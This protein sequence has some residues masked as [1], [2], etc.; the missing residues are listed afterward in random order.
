MLLWYMDFAGYFSIAAV[1]K[2]LIIPWYYL[3]AEL[4]HRETVFL[5]LKN[6]FLNYKLAFSLVIHL[7]PFSCMLFILLVVGKW[8]NTCIYIRAITVCEIN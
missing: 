7:V 1:K 3:A 8:F 2:L 5:L 4:I 6:K